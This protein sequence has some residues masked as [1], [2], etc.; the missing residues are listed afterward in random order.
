MVVEVRYRIS[1]EKF[2]QAFHP[3]IYGI[4]MNAEHGGGLLQIHAA[5]VNNFYCLHERLILVD[6][7]D[8][9]LAA[10]KNIEN[11]LSR[12]L[13]K[14]IFLYII[15]KKHHTVFVAMN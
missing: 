7:F 12:Y 11:I 4:A 1:A 15:D 6:F 9:A 13:G 14:K 8:K 3:L 5:V 2:I 10:G